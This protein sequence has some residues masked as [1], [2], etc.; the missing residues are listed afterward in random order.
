MECGQM[1]ARGR[2][3]RQLDRVRVHVRHADNNA[4]NAPFFDQNI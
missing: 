2:V 1:P 4:G 3:V